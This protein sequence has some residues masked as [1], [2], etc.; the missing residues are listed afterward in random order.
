[1]VEAAGPD[2]LV[3]TTAKDAVKLRGVYPALSPACVVAE[4]EVRVTYG[5]SDLA[6]LLDRMARVQS[7]PVRAADPPPAR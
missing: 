2:G 1:V 6:R 4:L 5:A 3:V 7:N